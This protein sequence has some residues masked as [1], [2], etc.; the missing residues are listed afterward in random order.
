PYIASSTKLAAMVVPH[1]AARVDGN[2]F[3]RL[4]AD[5][6]RGAELRREISRD[7]E[8]R[9]GGASIRIARDDPRPGWAGLDLTAIAKQAGTTPLEVVL[10]IQRHGGAQAISFGMS[11]QDVREVMRHAFV[12]TASDGGTHLPGRGDVP[13]PR[14]YGT[15]PRKI[16]YALD[17]KVLSLE[18]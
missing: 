9:D 5:P 7:L 4:A 15:F 1:W 10:D 8:G 11:E 16:R 3:A 13:H 14:S 2:E 12:A 6:V 18:Q 17:D